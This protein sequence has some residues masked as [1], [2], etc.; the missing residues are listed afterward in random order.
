MAVH[1]LLIRVASLAVE[2]R[3]WGVPAS[4]VVAHRLICPAA[5]GIFLDQS[6]NCSPAL[7]GRFLTTEPSG[8]TYL[9]VLC[10]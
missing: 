10:P 5:C 8:K 2:H 7:A 1:G 9:V 4:V 6:S 3:L